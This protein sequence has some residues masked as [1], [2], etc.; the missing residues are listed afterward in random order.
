MVDREPELDTVR[1]DFAAGAGG[2]EA[3]PGVVD[4]PVQLRITVQ[5]LIGQPVNLGQ[6]G[7][8]SLDGVHFATGRLADLLAGAGQPLGVATVR[9]D[10]GTRSGKVVYQSPAQSAGRSGDQHGLLVEGMHP[11]S[12][13]HR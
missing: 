10:G 6:V 9:D 5:H 2:P 12:L 7:E 3:H 8:I 13:R 4:Q 11:V 1:T